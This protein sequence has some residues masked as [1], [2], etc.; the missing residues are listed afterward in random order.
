LGALPNKRSGEFE[1][2]H[3]ANIVGVGCFAKSPTLQQQFKKVLEHFTWLRY[4]DLC[5]AAQRIFNGK[6]A[7]RFFSS[8]IRSGTERPDQIDRALKLVS[9]ANQITGFYLGMNAQSLHLIVFFQ[10]ANGQSA[11]LTIRLEKFSQL[12]QIRMH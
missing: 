3:I 11:N 2:N 7:R 10:D 1:M 8:V 9:A 5:P 4:E 12:K 6:N